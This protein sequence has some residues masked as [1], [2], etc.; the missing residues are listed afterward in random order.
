MTQNFGRARL[1]TGVHTGRGIDARKRDAVEPVGKVH[2]RC[3]ELV[4]TARLTRLRRVA[5][6]IDDV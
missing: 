3:R 2:M 4:Q 5:G 1:A 6:W